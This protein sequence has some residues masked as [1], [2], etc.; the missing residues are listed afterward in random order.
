MYICYN[1][2]DIGGIMVVKYCNVNGKKI[3]YYDEGAGIPVLL[4]HGWGQNKDSFAPSFSIIS[5]EFRFISIDLPGHGQSDEPQSTFDLDEYID[6]LAQFLKHIDMDNPIVIAHSFGARIALKMAANEM[7]TNKLILTGAA[8]LK[9]KRSLIYYLKVYN[10]KFMKLLVK[11]P[12]YHQ[13]ETALY[14]MSGSSDYAN[15]SDV[16]KRVL[17][18]AVN[19]D[20]KPL[21]SKVN[22]QVLLFWG[23]KDEATP[24]SDGRYLDQKLPSSKLIIT[25]GTHYS[26]IE[27]NEQ[28]NEEVM[29]FIK[30]DK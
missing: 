30:E 14:K 6:V 20:L 5:K 21:I 4:L 28:F 3:S 1:L 25:P 24:L 11:T 18:S 9:P 13:Y 23:E 26:F 8:G 16:M 17:V 27:Y 19:E 2:Y 12:F 22:N 29:K 7:L 15:A 10:Y